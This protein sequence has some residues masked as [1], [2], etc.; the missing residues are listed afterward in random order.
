M[1]VKGAKVSD[2]KRKR[3]VYH[4]NE[5]SLWLTLL[6]TVRL[7]FILTKV[8]PSEGEA[9]EKGQGNKGVAS[10]ARSM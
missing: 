3:S 7:L 9:E 1:Q 8:S 4:N 6:S 5:K 2:T 10:I